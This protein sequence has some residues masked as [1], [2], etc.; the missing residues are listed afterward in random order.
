ML[1]PAQSRYINLFTDF[2]FKKMFGE[3]A[4]KPLLIALL[5]DL[6]GVEPLITDL[7]YLK[8]ERLGTHSGQRSAIYD[9]YCTNQ[10][11]EKFIVEIQRVKQ[12]HFKDRSLFY[13]ARA[14]QEEAK[15]GRKW[16]YELQNIYTVA[17]MDFAFDNQQ[18]D[19]YRH[20]VQLMDTES[21]QVFTE[22]LTFLYFEVPKFNKQLHELETN[23][24]RW[25]YLFKHLH[26]LEE[27]PEELH[28]QVFVQLSH[29]AEIATMSEKE[30]Q[31]YEESLKH[32][33]DVQATKMSLLKE[34]KA[35]GIALGKAE[36]RAEG[37]TEGRTE[38]K[39]EAI[40]MVIISCHS[41]G[42]SVETNSKL[43]GLNLAEV[44]AILQEAGL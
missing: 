33:R 23:I 17:M 19:K 44:Q 34:G 13:A 12:E 39:K 9:L 3:E 26:Q 42:L 36:G 21:K 16:Y 28:E 41:N 18:P 22:R 30:Q 25:L 37:R 15:K 20:H 35:E 40:K 8:N 29:L 32:Y 31:R 14:L 6:L 38:G 7:I 5:N 43:T 24:E 27:L 4:N 11:G 1:S 2:G 10:Q